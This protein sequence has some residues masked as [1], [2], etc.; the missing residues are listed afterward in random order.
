MKTTKI[1]VDRYAND[2][3][4]NILRD[5]RDLI[6]DETHWLKHAMSNGR[7]D[8]YI[9]DF[10][11]TD[12]VKAIKSPYATAFCARG[13]LIRVSP[14]PENVEAYEVTKANREYGPISEAVQLLKNSVLKLY[15]DSFSLNFLN[16]DMIS[17]M[18]VND[19][20]GHY[21]TLRCFDDAIAQR[22]LDL[23]S[24]KENNA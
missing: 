24:R 9:T 15:A 4:L 21:E 7:T 5:A 16:L 11:N 23:T 6:L 8:F 22:I 19:R 2:T 13:A 1:T 20:L 3:V 14:L 18:D 17:I 10:H 12:T